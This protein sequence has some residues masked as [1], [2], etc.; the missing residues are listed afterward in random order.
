[1]PKFDQNS[2]MQVM[3]TGTIQFSAIRPDSSILGSVKYTLVTV[4]LDVTGS[5][6]D[7]ADDLIKMVLAV[8]NACKKSPESENL[9]L[10][11]VTFNSRGISE[12]HGFKLLSIL[13]MKDYE[14]PDCYGG[15]PLWD[16]TFDAIDATLHYS[17]TLK[18]KDF[19][20]NGCI[21]IITDGDNN[22]SHVST[23][24]SIKKRLIDAAKQEVIESLT[25]ILIGINTDG[26]GDNNRKISDLLEEFKTKAGLT[27]YKDAGK[28][29]PQNL[30]KL[31]GFVSKSV[32]STS[33]A[34]GTGAPSQPV[35]SF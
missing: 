9:L 10:R 17:Q 30:A 24:A 29:T 20:V 27:Q 4:V 6:K 2:E 7:F 15:T 18:I 32:S 8:I 13:D 23:P 25:T 5:V 33:Q 22:D 3:N 26:I 28:A 31:A 16:A 21:Y 19:E 35:D 14:R 34:V 12:K 11:F 1:M